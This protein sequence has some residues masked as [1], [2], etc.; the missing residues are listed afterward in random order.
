M[1]HIDHPSYPGPPRLPTVGQVTIDH[2]GS[3][4]VY[5]QLAT[6]LRGQID[7]GELA[8]DRPIP[9]YVTLMQQYEVARGTVAKAVQILVREGLVK[10]VPGRGA[11]VTQPG[12]GADGTS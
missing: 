12:G 11:Y 9:S 8:P 6:I 1:T 4:P 7:R 2:L 5:I 3:T 10:I